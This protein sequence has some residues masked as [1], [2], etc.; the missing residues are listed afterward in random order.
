MGQPRAI[1]AGRDREERGGRQ[2]SPLSACISPMVLTLVG[3]TK[4]L[5]SFGLSPGGLGL[6]LPPACTAQGLAMFSCPPMYLEYGGTLP[7]P[8]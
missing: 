5:G 8:R 1:P 4:F 2:E 6:C 3:H 7:A